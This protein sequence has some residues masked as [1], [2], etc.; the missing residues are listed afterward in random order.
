MKVKEFVQIYQADPLVQI[1]VSKL[2]KTEPSVF[3][4]GLAGS[5]DAVVAAAAY[6]SNPQSALFIVEDKDA[7]AYLLDD[8]Q[9][10]LEKDARIFLFPSSYKKAY[11]YE[12][13]DN[14]NVLQRAEVLSAVS[15]AGKEKS[16]V[17]V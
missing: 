5:L 3:L 13:I 15:Q 4:K 8:L 10:L 2:K 16:P 6:Y 7:A 11:H 1:L 17:L 14:A 9:Q 12:E